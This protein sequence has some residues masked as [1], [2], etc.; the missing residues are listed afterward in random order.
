MTMNKVM[1]KEVTVV[2]NNGF[3][4]VLT[5]ARHEVKG[6]K[7]VVPFLGTDADLVK[8]YEQHRG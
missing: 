6:M 3:A 5:E 7:D 1:T 2:D 4:K 8:A